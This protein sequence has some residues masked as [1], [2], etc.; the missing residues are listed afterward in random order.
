MKQ[1][2]RMTTAIKCS[3]YFCPHCNHWLFQDGVINAD[4]GI[5]EQ[6]HYYVDGADR[7]K[8]KMCN[9]IV[10]LRI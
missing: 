7:V 10:E 8:C 5:P 4:L 1:N 2:R 3:K 6:H 9:N